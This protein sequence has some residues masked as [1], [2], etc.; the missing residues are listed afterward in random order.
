MNCSSTPSVPGQV[1]IDQCV[2]TSTGQCGD[3]WYSSCRNPL[4][5]LDHPTECG[6]LTVASIALDP[7]LVSI[8]EE[9]SGAVRVIATFSDGRTAD[10]TGE[11]SI[12]TSDTSVSRSLGGGILTGEAVGQAVLTASWRS[13][14][15]QGQVVVFDNVCVQSQPWDVVV[16]ADEGMVY[17]SINRASVTGGV[18]R[19]FKRLPSNARF[20]YSAALLSLQ[21]S[22]DLL[23]PGDYV[24]GEGWD[25]STTPMGLGGARAGNDRIWA[26][27]WSQYVEST[28]NVVAGAE[29]DTGAQLMKAF[30]IHQGGRVDARKIV[31]LLSTGG[32][33]ICNPGISA[34]CAALRNA[35]IEVV[36]ITPLRSTDPVYNACASDQS[37]LVTAHS[38]LADSASSDCLFFDAAKGDVYGQV[39][40]IVCGGCSGSGE[41]IGLNAL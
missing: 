38:V 23:D 20:G 34:A 21:L 6:L 8:A 11:S 15:A 31:V 30:E 26:G 14:L 39:M 27:R 19:A 22:M 36:V 16:V 2:E 35:D 13:K 17:G 40:R 29:G 18:V 9:R 7:G 24:A 28:P 1:V 33:T 25:G 10:V 32:E 5:A 41:G 3:D 37:T 4:Y 12:A